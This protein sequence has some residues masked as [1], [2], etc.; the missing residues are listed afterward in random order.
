MF[1]VRS[2][3]EVAGILGE[4]SRNTSWENCHELH[5]GAEAL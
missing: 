5:G 3:L 1:F 4:Y 2:K